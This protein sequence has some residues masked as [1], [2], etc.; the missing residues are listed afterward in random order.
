M[1]VKLIIEEVKLYAKLRLYI[2]KFVFRFLIVYIYII[3]VILLLSM[4]NKN[5][6]YLIFGTYWNI[7]K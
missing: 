6:V 1:C 5:S 2:V 7:K 4:E 3:H